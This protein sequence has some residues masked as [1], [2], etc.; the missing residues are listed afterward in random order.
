LIVVD[1]SLMVAWLLQ[2]DDIRIVPDIYESLPE[3]DIIVPP[4][5]PVEVANALLTN[6]RRRRLVIEDLET[7]LE[8]LS[9]FRISF[10]EALTI[11]QMS[12]LTLFAASQNLTVYDA[13]YVHL[14]LEENIA[15]AT[16]DT[17][18]RVAAQSLNIPLI[19]RV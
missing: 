16:F 9:V 13:R 18:M 3:L 15:L 6:V 19:P 8:G 10:D 5:W 17:A 2:E 4:H 1:A 12:V 14:A 11:D 7:L